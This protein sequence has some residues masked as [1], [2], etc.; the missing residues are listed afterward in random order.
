MAGV[1]ITLVELIDTATNVHNRES[2]DVYA[3]YVSKQVNKEI[4]GP[5][6]AVK[7]LVEKLQQR[8]EIVSLQ[9][10]NVIE[11]CVKDCGAKFH[12]EIGKYKFI[13]ELIKLLSPKYDGDNTPQ[14]VKDRIIELLFSWYV[15]L[16]HEKKIGEA[17][18]MLKQ[19]GIIKRDPI[20][21]SKP[22][23]FQPKYSEKT[24]FSDEGNSELLKTLLASKNP[25]DLQSANKLIKSL[26]K[27]EEARLERVSKRIHD[28]ELVSNNV[29]LLD[30][31]LS[32]YNLA[33]PQPELDLIKELYESCLQMRPE[34]FRLASNSVIDKDDSMAEILSASDE[35]TRV[36]DAYK[37]KVLLQTVESRLTKPYN[38][39]TASPND[40]LLDLG[41]DSKTIQP[42]SNISETSLLEEQFKM[43]GLDLTE[44]TLNQNSIQASSCISLSSNILHNQPVTTQSNYGM[45][46]VLSS[47]ISN[48]QPVTIQ[49]SY[50]MQQVLQQQML[51]SYHQQ[52][53]Q[54]SIRNQPPYY[55]PSSAS[56]VSTHNMANVGFIRN[57]P[58]IT[59]PIKVQEPTKELSKELK[60]KNTQDLFDFDVFS[61]FREPKVK[62]KLEEHNVEFLDKIDGA[63]QSAIDHLL[64]LEIP[65]NLTLTTDK[66]ISSETFSEKKNS[67]IF[68]PKQNYQSMLQSFD[69]TQTSLEITSNYTKTTIDTSLSSSQTSY[70]VPLETLKPTG[71][72]PIVILDKDGLKTFLNIVSDTR[73]SANPNVLVFILSTVSTSTHPT[74][75][76][77][78]QVAVP[79]V[80][81]VKLQPATSTELPAFNP[82]LPPPTITQIMLIANPTKEEVRL[83]FKIIYTIHGISSVENFS[84]DELAVR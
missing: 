71:H 53:F 74:N 19:Q 65:Q 43:L 20:D 31:M 51:N 32:H 8:Q 42:L 7:V 66:D 70:L 55:Y 59:T 13:N 37:E 44:S 34:L 27:E 2:N 29:K 16:P 38:I 54:S 39:P 23:E 78:I 60:N 6:T 77:S 5:H 83:R 45:Q 41:L 62:S 63:N 33:T 30:D 10:L 58:V 26:V 80:M 67:F 56:A 21:S 40:S 69:E 52:S 3:G 24:V 4:D 25:D 22:S 46:Q 84:I 82:I 61:E 48:N 47:N 11:R 57:A 68:T 75:N 76:F 14:T 35:L 12:Q 17:Y 50:G 15:G 9:T 79:K 28:L 73:E 1:P 72:A 81:R 36:I 18:R 64:D 49:S